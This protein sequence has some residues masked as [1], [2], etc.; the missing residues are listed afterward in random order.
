MYLHPVYQIADGI[1]HQIRVHLKDVL[2]VLSGGAGQPDMPQVGK[3][4]LGAVFPFTKLGNQPFC[5]IK[6]GLS[7]SGG[8]SNNHFLC[9]SCHSQVFFLLVFHPFPHHGYRLTAEDGKAGASRKGIIPQT[10]AARS[11]IDLIDGKGA[12]ILFQLHPKRDKISHFQIFD[13]LIPAVLRLAN[14]D[15][16]AMKL[17]LLCQMGPAQVGAGDGSFPKTGNVLNH[18]L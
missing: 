7:V 16:M 3:F 13:N 18:S 15:V 2:F 11:V 4:H 9:T 12:P 8:S 1:I 14:G 17:Q 6:L 10:D 5:G